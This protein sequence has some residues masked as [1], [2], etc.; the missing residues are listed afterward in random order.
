MAKIV[1]MQIFDPEQFTGIGEPTAD[2]ITVVGEDPVVS[3]R[4]G[5]DDCPGFFLNGV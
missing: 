2:N 4:H 3:A 1:E 5:L